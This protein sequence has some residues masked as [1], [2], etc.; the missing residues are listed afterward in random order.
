MHVII[1][2]RLIICQVV[3]SFLG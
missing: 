3:T 2:V 1:E